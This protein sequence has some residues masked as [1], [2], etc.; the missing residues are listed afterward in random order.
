MIHLPC[1]HVRYNSDRITDLVSQSDATILPLW[2]CTV[3]IQEK[4]EA[5][6]ELSK[7]K[8]ALRVAE[9]RSEETSQALQQ[10]KS[11]K[12]ISLTTVR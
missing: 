12:E 6:R 2:P 4:Q 1:Y 10:L 5:D 11:A 8:E 3:F 7:L 9:V